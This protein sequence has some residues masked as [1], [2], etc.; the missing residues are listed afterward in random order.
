MFALRAVMAGVYLFGVQGTV[1]SVIMTNPH[2]FSSGQRPLKAMQESLTAAMAVK[3]LGE[4]FGMDTKDVFLALPEGMAAALGLPKGTILNVTNMRMDQNNEVI[5]EGTLTGKDLKA[6]KNFILVGS[7]SNMAAALGQKNDTKGAQL[8][9][10]QEEGGYR[11]MTYVPDG[12]TK[13]GVR[14]LSN[15][16]ELLNSG[17]V[18]DTV[19]AA[20]VVGGFGDQPGVMERVTETA[21]EGTK[22]AVESIPGAETI[23]KMVAPETKESKPARPTEKM[24]ERPTPKSLFEKLLPFFEKN[25]GSPLPMPRGMNPL[26][27]NGGLLGELYVSAKESLGMWDFSFMSASDDETATNQKPITIASA[28]IQPADAPTGTTAVKPTAVIAPEKTA[29]PEPTAAT[30]KP[31]ATTETKPLETMAKIEVPGKKGFFAQIKEVVSSYKE[32]VKVIVDFTKDA[33]KALGKGAVKTIGEVKDKTIAVAQNVADTVDKIELK[34]ENFGIGLNQGVTG[35]SPVVLKYDSEKSDWLL[36]DAVDPLYKG[37]EG[38]RNSGFEVGDYVHDRALDFVDMFK[39]HVT[40]GPGIK[41]EVNVGNLQVVAGGFVGD[42]IGFIGRDMGIESIGKAEVGVK[43]GPYQIKPRVTYVKDLTGQV[44]DK[45]EF[46]WGIRLGN[47]K[48]GK[49]GDVQFTGDI[50]IKEDFTTEIGVSG[51]AGMFG[52]ELKVRPH[53]VIDFVGGFVGNDFLNDDKERNT[54]GGTQ[55]YRTYLRTENGQPYLMNQNG[56]G[57]GEKKDEV[58]G[59]FVRFVGLSSSVAQGVGKTTN[60]VRV[61]G[62]N[63]LNAGWQWVSDVSRSATTNIHTTAVLYRDD[64]QTIVGAAI[65]AVNDVGD[66]ATKNVQDGWNWSKER[67]S[68]ISE[69]YAKNVSASFNEM[70]HADPVTANKVAIGMVAS[71]FSGDAFDSQPAF[72]FDAKGPAVVTVNGVFTSEIGGRKMNRAINISLGIQ[73]SVAIV[74]NSHGPYVGDILQVAAHEYLGVIDTPAVQTATAVR[75]GISEK[76]EVYLIAHS[77]GTAISN[78]ALELLTPAE[79]SKVHYLG[80]GSETYISANALGLADAK[81][82]RNEGDLVPVMG[83]NVRVSN[84]LNP[85]EWSRKVGTTWT[86]INQNANGNRHSFKEFYRQEVDIWA[87]ERGLK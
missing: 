79:R 33:A 43:A 3:K 47:W 1:G 19:K 63:I 56:M 9:L 48:A 29:K 18:R 2:I 7:A 68:A 53:E 66:Y 75:Q 17:L 64:M 71:V 31:A 82:I 49:V 40:V 21:V 37:N 87:K 11:A 52:G 60:D 20:R 76:G 73:N 27:V 74:N 50:A 12:D 30:V 65:G 42:R 35:N 78:A 44:S 10:I 22:K 54:W 59:L 77:Q 13:G 70:S 72:Q 26:K 81:N 25:P 28:N 86:Q 36:N 84:W 80:L 32:D 83:N 46:T 8:L 39:A 85:S 61:V 23:M 45:K 67:A 15:P 69:P 24:E 58:P 5:L 41:G 62:T 55:P 38:P 14:V 34:V 57:A 6:Q 51:H 16:Q 4:A